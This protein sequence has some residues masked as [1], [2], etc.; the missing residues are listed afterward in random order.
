MRT[1][2]LL[3]ASRAG[4]AAIATAMLAATPAAA[5][6]LTM[7]GLFPAPWREAAMLRSI[8]VERLGGRDG[9]ATGMAIERALSRPS[10]RTGAWFE[11]V[12]GGRRNN[13]GYAD[14]TLSGAVSSGV[15]D[16]YF[17]RPE[18]QCTQRDK[19]NKCTKEEEVQ[20]NCTRRVA[21]LS[22][23]LRIVRRDGRIVYSAVKPLREEITWCQGQSPSRTA[24]EM[25]N[26][27][28]G[29][30][31]EGVRRDTVP[32]TDTYSIRI[33][34]SS[35]GIP[36]EHNRFFKD[37]IKLTQRNPGQ[38]CQDWQ[39]LNQ[40]IPNNGVIVF[41]IGLCTEW[42]GDLQGAL[43]WYRQASPLLGRRNNEAD[44]GLNRVERR[45]TADADYAER[46]RAR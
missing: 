17:K 20:V 32:V 7:T 38:A 18:K 28:I 36:K 43:R 45:L 25:I 11:I 21:N 33:L 4:I 42:R 40:M 29:Q 1:L 39:R 26:G 16:S 31:A 24:E 10:G 2:F 14:G 22:A 27:M 23:D 19:D 30:I 44:T 41:N 35:K 15:E 5:E 34:E 3:T 13:G 12:Y 37:T 9:A 6:T 46:E 8:A